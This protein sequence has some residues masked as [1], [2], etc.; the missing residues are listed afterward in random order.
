MKWDTKQ[1]KVRVEAD[2]SIYNTYLLSYGNTIQS[3]IKGRISPQLL[4]CVIGAFPQ[5]HSPA[6]LTHIPLALPLGMATGGVIK[7]SAW[8]I[9]ALRYDTLH[10]LTRVWNLWS[11]MTTDNVS[12]KLRIQE[13]W[14][15]YF[16]NLHKISFSTRCHS[17]YNTLVWNSWS[18]ISTD[19]VS[20]KLRIQ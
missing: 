5:P 8:I 19:N 16:R 3:S 12:Q 2:P 11:Y 1:W 20:R 15:L 9:L 10:Y 14:K 4:K 13:E 7:P 17:A 6:N 18:Y